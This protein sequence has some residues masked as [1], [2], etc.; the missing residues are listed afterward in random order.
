[1]SRETLVYLSMNAGHQWLEERL[2]TLLRKLVLDLQVL[3]GMEVEMSNIIII[4]IIVIKKFV[5]SFSFAKLVH[6]FSHGCR[7]SPSLILCRREGRLL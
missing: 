6:T 1:M 3:S 4:I 7:R 5:E 2:S